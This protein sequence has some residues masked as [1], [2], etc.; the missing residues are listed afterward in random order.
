MIRV[1]LE[2][3]L[4]TGMTRITITITSDM[5]LK[6]QEVIKVAPYYRDNF[7]AIRQSLGDYDTTAMTRIKPSVGLER[8]SRHMI[9]SDSRMFA[10]LGGSH[11]RETP[12]RGKQN[13]TLP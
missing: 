11:K 2:E 9:P 6:N 7:V 5:T 3:F 10:S 1:G 13:T 4:T 12:T 8:C